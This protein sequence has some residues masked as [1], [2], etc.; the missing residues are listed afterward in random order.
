MKCNKVIAILLASG[1]MVTGLT[2]CADQKKE[3]KKASTQTEQKK[4][5]AVKEMKGD[6]LNKIMEDKKEKEKY[7]VIDVRSQEEYDKGHV[8]YAINMPI[9]QFESMIKNIEDQKDKNVVTICNTG[10]KSA[11]AA[12][13]LVKKGFMNV[14]NAQGVK[15]FK[16]K[17][18]T[19]VT[20]VRGAEMQKIANEGKYT[21]IDARKA[22]DFKMGHLKGAMNIEVENIDAKMSSI[23]KD[24]PVAVY[25]YSGN[26]S[27]AI[28]Q[29]L[30]DAG[31]K[32]TSSLD[33][34]KEY[35]QFEL[36]K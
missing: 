9:D 36:V 6:E 18:M 32:A 3:E 22:E 10:K 8:K 31:Y 4:D 1:F 25:C 28:A 7:L 13:M 12:D 14:Y 16:Y 26:K 29:K 5:A 20:N 21:I 24:K 19:M 33:G 35:T 27:M 15:D 11:K 17:T 2:G 30:S 23:A 34:T